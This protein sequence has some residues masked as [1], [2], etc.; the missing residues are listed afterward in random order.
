MNDALALY[1]QGLSLSNL[2]GKF[3]DFTSHYLGLQELSSRRMISDSLAP[4]FGQSSDRPKVPNTIFSAYVDGYVHQKYRI[5]LEF[6]ALQAGF[7]QAV[8]Y[9]ECEDG[10]RPTSMNR[11]WFTGVHPGPVR[12]IMLG[13]PPDDGLVLAKGTEEQGA[14]NIDTI[15]GWLNR[16]VQYLHDMKEAY[17]RKE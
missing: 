11:F 10:M 15:E 17:E 5:A 14:I 1:K 12:W 13:S 6:C 16:R 4:W 7:E 8:G 2:A 9:V 3:F